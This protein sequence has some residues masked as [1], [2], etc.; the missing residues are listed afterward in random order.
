MKELSTEVSLSPGLEVRQDTLQLTLQGKNI[1]FVV[2]PAAGSGLSTSD[3]RALEDALVTVQSFGNTVEKQKTIAP[4]HATEISRHALDKGFDTIVAV[5]GDGTL[6][7]IVQATAGSDVALGM[8]PTGFLN[9]WAREMMIP[10]DITHATETVLTGQIKTVDLGKINDMLY[11]QFANVGFDSEEYMKSHPPQTVRKH[12]GRRVFCE[13]FLRS[14]KDGWFYKGHKVQIA[15]DGQTHDVN[16]LLIGVLGNSTKYGTRTWREDAV[17]DD[18][19]FELTLSVGKSGMKFLLQIPGVFFGKRRIPGITRDTFSKPL[20]LECERGDRIGITIDG[21]PLE[22]NDHIS[23]EA[24]P[25][26]QRVLVPHNAPV[27]LFQES[28]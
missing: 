8:L 24:L 2:N 3:E 9:V 27:T 21:N 20:T 18:G 7:E 26:A 25:L 23:A 28:K 22:F 13:T 5:G 6:N 12:S 15:Y 16:N 10:Q 4:G 17:L 19:H 11:L 14:M 1:L